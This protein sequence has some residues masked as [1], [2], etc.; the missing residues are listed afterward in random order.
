MKRIKATGWPPEAPEQDLA[1]LGVAAVQAAGEPE[2]VGEDFGGVVH[3]AGQFVQCCAVAV[4]LS[5]V[6]LWCAFTV[7]GSVKSDGILTT[8]L[9]N[10]Y[11]T[12]DT[13]HK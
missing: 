1:E 11:T 7:V 13:V 8:A 6:G 12:D 10:H 9:V 4:G 2:A 5:P 3:V